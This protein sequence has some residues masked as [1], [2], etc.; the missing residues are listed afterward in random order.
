MFFFLSKALLFLIRPMFWVMVLAIATFISKRSARRRRYALILLL[1]L[2]FFSNKGLFEAVSSLWELPPNKITQSYDIGILLGGYSKTDG[3]PQDGRHHFN[4]SVNRLTQTL[5]LYQQG[6][7]RNILLTGGSANIIT[8]GQL[9]AQ[10][11]VDFIEDMGIPRTA[12]IV[13]S[14]ARNTWEN[15]LNSTQIIQAKYPKASCV[16]ITS[17]AHMRR[18]RA[19]F[20]KAGLDI[21]YYCTDYHRSSLRGWAWLKFKPG[22]IG[23]WEG[24]FKEWV[25]MLV[26]AIKGYV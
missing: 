14:Q 12:V 1:F 4:A 26:Y 16:L 7:I 22:V 11:V 13:E 19:C 18:A 23:D 21:E 25:G 20:R 8:K 6:K 3:Y 17:A 9:E 5:E 15:A 24:L 10:V 2:I